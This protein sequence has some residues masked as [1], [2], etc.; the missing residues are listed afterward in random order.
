MCGILALLGLEEGSEKWRAAAIELAKKLRHRGPDWSGIYCKGNNIVCHE[1]LAIVDP[2]SGDQPLYSEDGT[3]VCAVNAEIYNHEVFRKDLE[4]DGWK[5]SS[6]SDC[7]III[8]LY[9]KYGA[10]FMHHVDIL[11]MFA[12]VLYDEKVD[13]YIACRDHVGIIP[14]YIGYAADGSIWFASELKA[15]VENCSNIEC[16]PP[17]H[18]Y[19]SKTHKFTPY[20][21]PKWHDEGFMPKNTITTEQLHDEFVKSVKSHLMSDVPY[22][23]LLSG[24]LDSSLLASIMARNLPVDSPWGGRLHSFSIGLRGSPDLK[25]ARKVA[26][27]L[28]TVHHEYTFTVQQG[29]DALSDVI[30]FTETYDVTS[31]RASTPMYLMARKIKS[32]G[33][34]MV[35]SGEGADEI[36]AGYLY[37][38]KCPNG[39][40][41]QEETVRKVKQLH[42]Y[43][44]LRANKSMMAWGVEARVPFLDKAFLRFAMQFDPTQKLCADGKMEKHILR[45]AFDTKTSSGD[46]AAKKRKL[47]DGSSTPSND[48][49]LPDE[50]LWRQKEQFS[51]GVGYS[52][53]DGVKAHANRLVSDAQLKQADRRFPI[54]TPKTKEAY[55]VRQIF[56]GH[57]PTD[58]AA[59]TVAWQDSIACSTA[60]ALKWDASFQNRTDDSGRSVAGVH[61]SAYG[62][63]F[64]VENKHEGL[65]GE[66]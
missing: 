33:V 40:E 49:Y 19:S 23:V 34:K 2:E 11:G 41:M 60:T 50:V 14:L 16:F 8:P 31:I 64:A 56:H 5:F 13:E 53:I 20:Y 58:A 61:N 30:Y 21:K 43:D 35:L 10:D 47:N 36:F 38:H 65:A 12:F 48:A 46:Q 9:E 24:G 54:N 18:V 4:S 45:S 17:G 62:E 37:F 7:A 39:K 22:G 28:G 15:L 42:Q 6:K 66:N 63:E 51:D 25:A 26:T 1:R 44:C 59:R 32:T 52:W 29:L 27:F 57:F 3:V 55:M